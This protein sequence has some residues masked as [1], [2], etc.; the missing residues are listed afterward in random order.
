[1]RIGRVTKSLVDPSRQV[2]AGGVTLRLRLIEYSRLCGIGTSVVA[3]AAAMWA[4]SLA[5]SIPAA[6]DTVEFA[7]VAAYE[8]NPQISVQR[9]IVRQ[10]D[11]QVPQALSG[12]RP[13]VSATATLGEQSGAEQET[14][15]GSAPVNLSGTFATYSTGITATQT[16]YNGFQTANRTRAAETQVSAARATLRNT[17]QTV[18]LNALTAYMNC[19]ITPLLNCRS[20]TSRS[21]KNSC[22]RHAIVFNS[23][24]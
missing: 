18:L 6:A 4:A 17:E 23:A 20:A 7:L 16:L 3:A 12:F 2:Q 15:P 13:R 11:E 21:Y 10:T 5:G 22:G 24:M 1:M 14:F 9:A 19:G 8:G